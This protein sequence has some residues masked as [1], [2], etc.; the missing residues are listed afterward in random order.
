MRRA[1]ALAL[2]LAGCGTPAP[3]P[4]TYVAAVVV[5]PVTNLVDNIDGRALLDDRPACGDADTFVDNSA[6]QVTVEPLNLDLFHLAVA[7]RGPVA[8]DGGVVGFDFL[9]GLGG[10]LVNPLTSGTT[11]QVSVPPTGPALQAIFEG[12]VAGDRGEVTVWRVLNEPSS[13]GD[14][15]RLTW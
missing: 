6:A 14:Q 4:G 12:R 3:E 5:V 10:E 15:L 13:C 11:I 9:P 2:A 7:Y 8:P 1:W